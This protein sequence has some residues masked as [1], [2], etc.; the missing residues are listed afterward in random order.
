M[1]YPMDLQYIINM[2]GSLSLTHSAALHNQDVK[3]TQS[4][5]VG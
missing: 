2:T 5:A 1:M 3:T 4:L